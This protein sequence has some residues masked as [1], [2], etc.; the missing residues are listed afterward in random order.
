MLLSQSQLITVF[1]YYKQIVLVTC[2]RLYTSAQRMF[3]T[4]EATSA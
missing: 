3:T 2:I 4:L 1:F